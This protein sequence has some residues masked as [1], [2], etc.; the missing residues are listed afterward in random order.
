MW[1]F[2]IDSQ[3]FF[4]EHDELIETRKGNLR[5][6]TKNISNEDISLIADTYSEKNLDKWVDVWDKNHFFLAI[7]DESSKEFFAYNDH[8]SSN[9]MLYHT[10]DQLTLCNDAMRIFKETGISHEINPDAV[11]ELITF[12]G[13]VP[14]K[15]IY[16]HISAVPVGSRLRYT[17]G[18]CVV[19]AYW[20]PERLFEQKETDYNKLITSVREGLVESY[21]DEGDF[22]SMGISL[23]SGVD[24]GGLLSMFTRE[25]QTTMPSITVGPYGPEYEDLKVAKKIAAYNQ[26]ENHALYPTI[27]DL[28]KTKEYVRGLNHP[29]D[30]GLLFANSIIFEKAQEL[31]LSKV[32]F[33]FGAEM[34]LGNLKIS[35]IAYYIAPI[36]KLIP[37][38]ILK[39]M[40]KIVSAIFGF[41]K[42][43]REFLLSSSW[44][45]R[46]LRGRGPLF[47]HE[48]KYF[49]NL[50]KN[51]IDQYLPEARR[52][53][54]IENI[55][56]L[57]KFVLFYL[58]SWV[59]Y[60]QMREF[61]MMGKKFGITPVMPFDTE[62]TMRA[63]FRTPDS[64]RKLNRWNKQ[65]IRDV[66][67]PY[68]TK[69]MYDG[70]V[71]SL[72]IP[73]S[74]WL[75]ESHP[76]FITYLKTSKVFENA[77]DIDAF[78]RLYKELPE[79][80]LSLIRLLGLAVWY[81]ANWDPENLKHFD[82]IFTSLTSSQNTLNVQG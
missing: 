70:R 15:T 19:T 63:I 80:G 9:D 36:E 44:V 12:F 57:D 7:F 61:T 10:G 72:I 52:I 38:S 30:L 11:H 64:F 77:I 53:L 73:Y 29:V 8:V 60:T 51:F 50:S 24:S 39:L 40:Y 32:V 55:G 21:K 68:T 37:F 18:E 82:T 13:V 48:K 31:G 41:S 14:P 23:S 25:M 20:H 46:F 74:V 76:I 62:K 69:D 26:S 75:K 49:K 67:K 28:Q 54:A 71:G 33:G 79:P 2:K 22:K 17:S 47:I 56:L 4:A 5:F 34:L 43:Q 66:F 35:R 81:D 42:N 6:F 3:K 27:Y 78:E 59:N 65:V 1:Y 45:D 16:V 58:Y